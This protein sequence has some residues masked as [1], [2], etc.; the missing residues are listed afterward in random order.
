V[1]TKKQGFLLQSGDFGK[2]LERL[3]NRKLRLESFIFL[4]IDEFKFKN[5]VEFEILIIS[6]IQQILCLKY[7]SKI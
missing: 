7:Q 6:F 1:E 2:F 4:E 3:C 5:L